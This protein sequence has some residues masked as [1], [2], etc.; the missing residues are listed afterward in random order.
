MNFINF[1]SEVH[2][3]FSENLRNKNENFVDCQLHLRVDNM[4]A[5]MFSF[6]K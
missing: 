2:K 6:L 3:V 1:S 5:N 4:Q